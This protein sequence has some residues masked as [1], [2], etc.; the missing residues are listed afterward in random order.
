[1]MVMFRLFLFLAIAVL[2]VSCFKED[3]TVSP[4]KPGNTEVDTVELTALYKYQVYY[5]LSSGSVSSVSL[6]KH[7][8]L[9]FGSSADNGYV[10]LNTSC[11]MYAT[12]LRSVPFGTAVDTS[13]VSWY[14]DNSNGDPDSTAIGIWYKV[15]GTDT[16]SN[17]KLIIL[18]RGIDEFG[19]I[20][21]FRQLMIDSLSN[22]TYYFRFANLDGTHQQSFQVPRDPQLNHILFSFDEVSDNFQEPERHSW[23]LL[24]T[25]YTTLL[26]TDLGEPYP[27][28]VTGV[29]LNPDLVEVARDSVDS[30]ENIN[31]TL[32][33]KLNYSKQQDFI[34]YDWKYYNFDSGAYTVRTN[35]IYVIHDE[36]GYYYKFRFLGFYNNKGEKGYPS[37]EFQRL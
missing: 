14:F 20:R 26:F 4:H 12:S 7:W 31:F 24:F 32:A 35:Q 22:N 11:F 29:L 10:R 13:D 25:Q 16:V 36:T 5:D 8:D 34:G 30:F 33:K 2:S 6:R 28:L 15:E 1:M 19:N 37:I 9:S 27:Y 23:D 17:G 3:E 21:G 18:N